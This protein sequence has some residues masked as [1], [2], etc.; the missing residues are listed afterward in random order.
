[1]QS[2]WWFVGAAVLGI[3]EMFTLDLTFLMLAAGALAGGVVLLLGGPLW[4]AIV[5]A[6]AVTGAGLFAI[7]PWLLKSLR[8]RQAPLVETNVAA[9]VGASAV[10]LDDVS[11]R[12]GRIKLRGEVWTARTVAGSETIPEGDKVVVKSIEGA[13]AIVAPEQEN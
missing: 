9:L 10:A 4:L 7:R 13:T 8:A 3:V 6:L 12:S 11:A 1:M 2:V 5:I